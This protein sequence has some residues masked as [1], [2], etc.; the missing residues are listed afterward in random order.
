MDLIVELS[1]S[2]G[3]EPIRTIEAVPAR[4]R[5]IDALNVSVDPSTS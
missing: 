1:P 5:R 3:L 2:V 4:P